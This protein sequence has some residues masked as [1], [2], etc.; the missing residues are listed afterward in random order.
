MQY[1]V[2][3]NVTR[4]RTDKFNKLNKTNSIDCVDLLLLPDSTT[5]CTWVHV[6]LYTLSTRV[7]AV[8]GRHKHEHRSLHVKFPR[9][10]TWCVTRGQV[11][12][13][14]RLAVRT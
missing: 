13:V 9:T 8:R 12:Q 1:V 14:G 7:R 10:F 6:N 5:A 4:A 3:Q 11:G 2:A